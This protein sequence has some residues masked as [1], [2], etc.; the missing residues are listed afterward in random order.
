VYWRQ[1][2]AA[3]GGRLKG[4]VNI[5]NLNSLKVPAVSASSQIALGDRLD[6]L[7]RVIGSVRHKI[8]ILSRLFTSTLSRSFGDE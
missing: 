6:C 8:E 5:E 1:I 2:D 3:K 7:D 4:G